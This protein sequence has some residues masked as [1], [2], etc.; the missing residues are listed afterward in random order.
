MKE[1][2]NRTQISM[3][4]T[5]W[6]SNKEIMIPLHSFSHCHTG[7]VREITVQWVV[8][9]VWHAEESSGRSVSRVLL[10]LPHPTPFYQRVGFSRQGAGAY[11]SAFLTDTSTD[12]E[13]Y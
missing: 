8:L 13:K 5:G 2:T 1:L 11:K 10:S 9:Q 6:F 7:P 12:S 4:L 3:F